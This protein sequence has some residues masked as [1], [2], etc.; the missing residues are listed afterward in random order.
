MAVQRKWKRLLPLGVVV[1]AMLF[2]TVYLVHYYGETRPMVAGLRREHA[3]KI[4][5]RTVYLTSREYDLAFMT[6]VLAILGLGVFIG[7]AIKSLSTKE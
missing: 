1:L 6:H 4:H 5:A 7:L 3:V 2:G